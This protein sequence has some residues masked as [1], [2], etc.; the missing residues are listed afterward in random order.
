MKDSYVN[1]EK[2]KYFLQ[3]LKGI[4]ASKTEKEELEKKIQELEKLQDKAIYFDEKE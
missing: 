4:F 2:L 3:K 1:A